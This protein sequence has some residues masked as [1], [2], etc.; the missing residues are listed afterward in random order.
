[1]AWGGLHGAAQVLENAVL[2]K[3]L[4]RS[5]GVSGAVRTLLVF[6]FCC[7]AW[8]FFVSDSLSNALYVISEMFSGIGS[9]LTYLRS[10]ISSIGLKT[11]D[12]AALCISVSL[13]FTYDAVSLK[14]DVISEISSRKTPV[15]WLVYIA[16]T[17][18]CIINLHSTDASEFIYF[19]F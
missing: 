8:I 9:P 11:A 2:P 16:F 15:R 3:K 10:G 4:S 14:R 1:M 17:L 6:A 19:Q 18:W 7:F 5:T 13:L 12:L